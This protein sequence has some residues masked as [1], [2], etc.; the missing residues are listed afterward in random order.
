MSGPTIS[1]AVTVTIE[2]IPTINISATPTTEPSAG[3]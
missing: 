3:E 1:N 2:G